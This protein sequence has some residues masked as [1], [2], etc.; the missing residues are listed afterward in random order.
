MA[1]AIAFTPAG[2]AR[3]AAHSGSDMRIDSL[4]TNVASGTF[5]TRVVYKVVAENAGPDPL[6]SSLD[7]IYNDPRSVRLRNYAFE[8]DSVNLRITDVNCYFNHFGGVGPSPD[9]PACEFGFTAVGNRVYMKVVAR[10]APRTSSNIAAL[11]FFVANESSIPDPN[12]SNNVV[13]S[14]IPITDG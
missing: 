12:P 2:V 8:Y 10:I 5:G 6:A 7:I 14:R 1:L 11:G 9:T 3:A 4:R 13:I